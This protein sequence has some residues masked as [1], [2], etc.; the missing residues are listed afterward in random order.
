MIAFSSALFYLPSKYYEQGTTGS[1]GNT[2][3][4]K[5]RSLIWGN[6]HH[7]NNL[8]NYTYSSFPEECFSTEQGL[9]FTWI[10]T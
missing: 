6:S 3:W 1:S 4:I 5:G 2:R 9:Y 10:K 8:A 7:E